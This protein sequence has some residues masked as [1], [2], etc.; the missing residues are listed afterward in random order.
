MCPV[1]RS[2]GAD[3]PLCGTGGIDSQYYRPGV[4]RRT[5]EESHLLSSIGSKSHAIL[6][7]VIV[8]P[9][10]M[11]MRTGNALYSAESDA[12]PRVSDYGLPTAD[13]PVDVAS[14]VVAR[15]VAHRRADLVVIVGSCD[16]A[17]ASLLTVGEGGVAAVG[18][19]VT[20]A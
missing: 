17:K 19:S 16:G 1:A 12:G 2:L 9:Y 11:L 14:V 10:K 15:C 13:Q 4:K 7:S 6:A 18:W 3:R 20:Q 8:T 5:T